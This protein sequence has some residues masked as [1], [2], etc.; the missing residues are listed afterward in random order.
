MAGVPVHHMADL[1]G[2]HANQGVVC[3]A[4]PLRSF[5]QC[6]RHHD[7]AAGQSEGIGAQARAERQLQPWRV[8][9]VAAHC[10]LDLPRQRIEAFAQLRLALRRQFAR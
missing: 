9:T 3:Q 1:M 7:G 2:E 6:V 4:L 10:G 5:D 8:G